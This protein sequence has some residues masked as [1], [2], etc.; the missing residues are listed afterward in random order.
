MHKFATALT[1]IF[2]FAC[3][4]QCAA[5]SPDPDKGNWHAASN[6]ASSITGD[7]T[8]ANAKLTLS[9]TPFPLASIR[10]ITPAEV[11]AIFDADANTAGPGTLYR[12][13]VPAAM[14]LLHHNTLCGS[15]ITQWMAT[16]PSGK[17][18]QVAFFSGDDAPALTF[19]AIANSTQVCG[20]FTYTR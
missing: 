6:T 15:E 5:Q 19:D 12:L 18:L 2:V 3:A 1:A 11:S 4:V 14:R 10:T 17:T 13:K 8:I 16:W 9:L 7:I 20:T